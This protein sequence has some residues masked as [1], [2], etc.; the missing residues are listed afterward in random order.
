MQLVWEDN[1][2]LMV[3][4]DNKAFYVYDEEDTES[5]E[6]L[7]TVTGGHKD[8]ISIVQY[9]DHLSLLATGS[10]DG[11]IIV[12]D[13]ETSKVESVLAGHTA[14]ITSLEFIDPYPLLV[15]ASLDCTVCIW[16]VRPI[17]L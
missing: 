3:C 12:W 15:S 6:L 4:C 14:D 11:E 17:P 16:G 8:E 2:I 5:S 1:Y 7:R 10:L 9:S 13:F